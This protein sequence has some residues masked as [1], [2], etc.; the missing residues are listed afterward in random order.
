VGEYL[1]LGQV[2]GAFSLNQ[3]VAPP[4]GARINRASNIRDL[5]S[6]FS[7]RRLEERGKNQKLK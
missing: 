7:P 2:L 3:L 5:I 6:G 1:G 4:R